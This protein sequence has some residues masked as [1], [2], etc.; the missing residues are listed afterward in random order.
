MIGV[1][2]VNPA[3]DRLYRIGYGKKAKVVP[4]EELMKAFGHLAFSG[5]TVRGKLMMRVT[6]NADLDTRV[7]DTDVEHDFPNS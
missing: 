4:V 2:Y 7:D 1:M 3:I 5:Y 6:R